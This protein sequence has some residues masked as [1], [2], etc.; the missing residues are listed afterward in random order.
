MRHAGLGPRGDVHDPASNFLLWFCI[1]FQSDGLFFG[2]FTA[3]AN[4]TKVVARDFT[5]RASCCTLGESQPVQLQMKL[6]GD[7]G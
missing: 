4:S 3:F 2:T 6:V 1:F 7:V 5:W